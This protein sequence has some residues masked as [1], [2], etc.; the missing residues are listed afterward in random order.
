MLADFIETLTVLVEQIVLT[1]GVPGVA[2]VALLENLFPPTPSEALYPLVGKMIYDGWSSIPVITIAGVLGSMMGALIFYTA[3]Y[4]LG[5]ERSRTAIEKLGTLRLGRLR[6][7]II[8]VSDYERGMNLFRRYGGIIVFVARLMPLVHGVVSIPAGVVRMN[9]IVFM[10]YTAVGAALWIGP[11]TI[12]GFWLGDNWEQ[13]LVW[14]D[15]YEYLI[16]ALLLL[17]A[18]YLFWRRFRRQPSTDQQP[19]ENP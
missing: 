3:G 16:Y 19:G 1:F 9:L 15:V 14:L 7:V 18:A 12:F 4:R 2:L 10:A 8:S 5:E 13:V 17:A 6:L 11:L